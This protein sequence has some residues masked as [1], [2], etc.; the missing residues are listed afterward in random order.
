M[1]LEWLTT[2]NPFAEQR[3]FQVRAI[4]SATL[5]V[6]IASTQRFSAQRFL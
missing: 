4:V 2:F 1:Q 3:F 5:S 6:A